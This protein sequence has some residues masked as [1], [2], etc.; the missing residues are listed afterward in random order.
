MK[1]VTIFN[2]SGVYLRQDFYQQIPHDFIDFTDLSGIHGFCEEE[3]A[4]EIQRRTRK[5]DGGIRFLD[6]GNFHYLSYLLLKQQKH[7]FTLVVLDH[8]TDM[9]DSAFGGLLS[10]GSW[11]KRAIEEVPGLLNVILIGVNDQLEE[12]IDHSYGDRV[13][14]Y[15]KSQLTEE[16]WLSGFQHKLAQYVYLS[17]DKDAFSTVETLT[18]WDQGTM[19]IHQFSRIWKAII[20]TSAVSAVDI[21]GEY[22]S[23]RGGHEWTENPDKQNNQFNK[24]LLE[25]LQE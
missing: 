20:E 10:C 13:T 9:M 5:V 22:D 4:E 11:I 1:K 3:A 2:M 16:G 19:T 24:K 6:S 14:V 12:T 7:P 18:D 15:F 23:Q 8:H 25:Q 21:C 17:V